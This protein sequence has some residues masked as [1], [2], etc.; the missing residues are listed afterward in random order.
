[1]NPSRRRGTAVKNK[2]RY[3]LSLVLTLMLALIFA[4]PAA[5]FADDSDYPTRITKYFNVDVRV[6]ENNSYDF[7][8]TVG[9]VFNTEGH[10]IYRNIPVMFDGIRER[11]DGGWCSTDPLEAYEEGDN[12]I[13]QMGSGSSYIYGDHEFRYGYRYTFRDDRDESGDY[14]YI[15]VLPTNWQTPIESAEINIEM[16]K[17]I[18][19]DWVTVYMGRYGAEYS[20]TY[21][22]WKLTGGTRL[23]I[24]AEDLEK[25]VGITVL[26]RLPEGYWVGQEDGQGTKNAATGMP[27]VLAL[28]LGGLWARFGRRQEIVETIEFRPPEGVTPAEIGLIIDG[29]LDKKDMVSMFVYFA[30]KGYMTIEEES[31]RSFI[32]T[33][34]REIGEDEKP[35]A[36]LLFDGLFEEGDVV[37]SDDMSEDFAY[38]YRSACETLQDDYGEVTPTSTKLMQRLSG[39]VLY[40][41]ALAIPVMGIG[42]M[43]RAELPVFGAILTALI[44]VFLTGRLRKSYRYRMTGRKIGSRVFRIVFWIIDIAALLFT[45]YGVGSAFDSVVVGA[46]YFLGFAVCQICNVYCGRLTDK[47]AEHMGKI[48][49]LKTFIQTAEVDRI[50]A[51]VEEDP[52]YFFNVLPYAYVMGL[53][54]KWISKFENINVTAP[55]WYSTYDTSG[56]HMMVFH[57]GNSMGGMTN[58]VTTSVAQHLPSGTFS[59]SDTGGGWSGGGG[60]SGGGGGFSGGGGGGGGGGFW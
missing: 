22:S 32:F 27:V 37:H 3:A 25:G 57:M 1:M 2:W 19:E 26:A 9:T 59:G 6:N 58:A 17:P 47:A 53:T 46:I 13:L 43:L 20:D 39:L 11:V 34:V 30:Q 23:N 60:F 7:T 51:L 52:E 33:K 28:L 15:D 31:K 40:I 21:D 44:A 8:E 14:M 45:A 38:S 12:Y 56:P 49:G 4:V 29:V 5:A 16:P 24:K 55:D 35:F 48:L 41:F 42:Y 36:R 50:E 18:N 10:G 54:N